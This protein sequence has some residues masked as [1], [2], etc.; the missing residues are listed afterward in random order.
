MVEKKAF[1]A[2]S[3]SGS[4][5]S[6]PAGGSYSRGPREGGPKKE[7]GE[8]KPYVKREGGSFE[9]KPRAEG[10]TYERK[11]RAE[12]SSYGERKPYAPR[13][14]GYERKSFGDGERKPYVKREGGSYERKS[15]GD[16]ERKPYVKREGG[17]Y[18]RKSFGDGERKPYVKREG[19]S[20][21]RKSFGDGERKPYVKREGGSYERKSFGDGERKP[22]VKREG[23]FDRQPREN[24]YGEGKVARF[25]EK[26]TIKRD[27]TPADQKIGKGDG[28]LV[29]YHAVLAALSAGRRKVRAVWLLSEAQ[30]DL[31]TLLAA[32]PDWNVEIKAKPDFEREFGELVHQGVAA[33]VGN[34]PQPSLPE[35]LGQMRDKKDGPKLIVALD[36]V[37]DPHNLGAVVRSAAAFGASGVLVT[38]HRAAGL[39]ATAAKVAAG[40]MEVV[41]VVEV[42]NLVQSI[43]MM[44]E[45]GFTVLGMT[46][47][48]EIEIGAAA[49][50]ATGPI[51]L[52]MGSE[53]EGLRR[54]T[55][56]TCDQ[57][58]KIAIA[59]AMESLN[60]SVATGVA[61]SILTRK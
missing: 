52:V 1:G 12:G 16:G 3:K 42:V 44:Q 34:L 58:V 56:E 49:A 18:E 39:N 55:R 41:P 2:R 32:N 48:A 38:E 51:C 6:K 10:S 53:G 19:G 60:V 36:Q 7:F 15:F 21:E 57:L 13:E 31:A 22:Y 35:L 61:L 24:N 46:G 59:P 27:R 37:T 17:S 25:S 43:E 29:G 11:P 33:L 50:A 9:R 23:G 40:A 47:D 5:S 45:A 28:W 14:G 30:G 20:Y 4:Y 8:R 26:R 54:L